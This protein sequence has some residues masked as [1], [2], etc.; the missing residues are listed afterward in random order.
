MLF[1][2]LSLAASTAVVINA[3]SNSGNAAQL[4]VSNKKFAVTAL[5][6]AAVVLSVCAVA[7]S[8]AGLPDCLS[9]VLT[10]VAAVIPSL[11][12]SALVVPALF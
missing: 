7:G 1:T 8:L 9:I 4:S 2:V 10:A 12:V 11:A 6:Y 5:I 3:A